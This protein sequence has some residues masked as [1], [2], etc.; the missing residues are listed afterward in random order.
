MNAVKTFLLLGLLTT[1]LVLAGDVLG[2]PQG[3]VL[4]FGFALV[5]NAAA[6]RWSDRIVL[7]GTHGRC[8]RCLEPIPAGRLRAL[9]EAVRCV[10]C[11][12]R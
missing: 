3:M 6:Y 7:E 11:A 9:P 10:S 2:G 1:L 5:M 4:A 12:A 8:E